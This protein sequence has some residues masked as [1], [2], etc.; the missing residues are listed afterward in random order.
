[1]T[2]AVILVGLY[3]YGGPAVSGSVTVIC[4]NTEFPCLSGECISVNITCDGRAD[5]QDGSDEL[6]TT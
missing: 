2:L 4:S 6:E 5:C 3:F 1:M